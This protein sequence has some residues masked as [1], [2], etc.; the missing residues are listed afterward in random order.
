ML[1]RRL[2]SYILWLPFQREFR[3]E[4]AEWREFDKIWRPEMEKHWRE[5]AQAA[6]IARSDIKRQ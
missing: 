5:Y 2:I 4:C 6:K 3:R 1:V